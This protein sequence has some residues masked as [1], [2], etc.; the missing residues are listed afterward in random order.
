RLLR[1]TVRKDLPSIRAAGELQMALC[2]PRG[3]L[4]SYMLDASNRKWL[5]DLQKEKQAFNERLAEARATVHTP[6]GKQDLDRLE[7]AYREYEEKRDEVVLLYSHGDL[8]EAK[9]V[10][11]VDVNDLYQKAF[12][13]V[14]NFVASTQRDAD[15]RMAHVEGQVAWVTGLV[16]VGVT[17]AMGLGIVLVWLF[18]YGVLLPLRRMMADAR[19][20][21]GAEA[22][23]AGESQDELRAVG[24]YLRA[25]MSDMADTRSNLE[26]SRHQ[27]LQSEKL[28]SVGKLA[29]SVAHEIR[30]PLTA[31]KMWLFSIRKTVGQDPELDHS[32]D[33]VS[34]EMGR[35][36]SI[37]RNFLEF[38]RPPALKVRPQC[39]SEVIDKTLELACHQIE[40]KKIDLQYETT[41]ELPPV[42][43]DREQL[44]QV[45]INLLTNAVEATPEEG[46]I[47][48]RTALEGDRQN[49]EMVVVRVQ[50]SGPGIP[51]E[52]QRRVFEP[53]FT[54]KEQGTGLGLCIAAQIMG[55]HGGRL[56]L[57]SST[58]QGTSFAVWIPAAVREKHEQDSRC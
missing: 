44:K 54:T 9:R 53:F 35:L 7:K 4:A 5:E 1:D 52:V 33:I 48:V 34:E 26:R 42:M 51:E 30:N 57:E 55:R 16:A 36:E 58:G 41:T 10:L 3:F 12:D 11:L 28:A 20:F 23:A 39:V 47:C 50:D 27:L 14:E 32:F 18:F 19:H 24:D 25:L 37:V 38:S 13:Q 21:S 17:V 31:M 15:T 49:G 56:A 8:E 46:R 22:P 43:A 40:E 45:L 6:E 2:E 29:A